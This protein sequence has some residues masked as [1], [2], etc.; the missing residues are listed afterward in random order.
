M[1]PKVSSECVFCGRD[2]T[3][4]KEWHMQIRSRGI[5]VGPC[6]SRVCCSDEIEDVL[7]DLYQSEC[8]SA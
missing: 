1:R 8:Q 6:C 4:G 2:I 3:P 7:E 5:E